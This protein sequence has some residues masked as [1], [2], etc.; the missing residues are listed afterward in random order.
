V[1]L[2]WKH[3][4]GGTVLLAIL[5]GVAVVWVVGTGL[6][7]RWML[8][9]IVSQIETNTGT[10]V[11]VGKFHFEFWRLRAEIDN[12][13]VH[14]L[15]G[16]GLPP[17]FH[18]DHI[19]IGVRIISFFR[20]EIALDELLA[21]R[22]QVVMRV[23][24][25]GKSNLPPPRASSGGAPWA[26]TLFNLRARH[27]ELRDGSATLNDRRLA[28]T[29]QGQDLNFTLQYAAPAAG[30]EA[31]LG[32]FSWQ[33]V[34]LAEQGDLPFRFDIS[35][36]F[37]LHRNAFDIDELVWKLPHSEL[38]LQAQ[39]PDLA[40]AD[41][42]FRYRGRLSLQDVRTIFRKPTTP[43]A[44]TDFSGQ[45]SYASE[46][47]AGSE[48]TTAGNYRSHDIKLPY[49]WFHDAG[50]ETSGDYTVARQHLVVPNL[51]V[52]A[53]GGSVDGRLEMD[54]HGLAFRTQTHLHGDSLRSIFAAL[55]NPDFPVHTLHWDASVDVD[56]VNTWNANFQH[57]RSTGTSVWS[58][59][60][61]LPVGTMPA[62]ATINYDYSNDRE[63]VV[64]QQSEI[65][66]PNTQV[67]FAGSL[68]AK[69]SALEVQL[70]AQN[71]TDWDDFIN[72]LR[73]ADA[74]PVAVSGQ[75][76]WTG[77]ILGPLGGPTFA[78]H[79]RA[80]QA[81]Y[82][83]LHWD[84]LDGELEYSPDDFRLTKTTVERG[85]TSV[86]MD[87]SLE[88]DGAWSFLPSSSWTLQAHVNRA[89]TEDVQ[90]VFETKYPIT[91]FLSGDI[92]GS[93][94]RAAPVL[95]ANLALE[96]IEATGFHFDRLS[97]QLHWEGD[98]IRLTGGELREGTGRLTGDFLYHPHEG[99][100]EFNLVGRA[101]SLE[102]IGA[103]QSASLPIS[104][105]L[106]FDL[107][108]SG[109]LRQ[110]VAQ[111]DL[112]LV[113][114]KLGAEVQGDFNGQVTSDGQ[115]AHVALT[116]ELARGKLDGQ[117]TMGF[118]G[119]RPI[120]GQISVQQFDIDPFITS[121]LYLKQLTGHS[122]VD[123]SFAISGA[124]RQPD[125]IEVDANITRAS[126][127]YDLVQLQNDGP[128]QLVYHR[129]EVRIG[130]LHLHGTDTDMQ[131]G[132]SA[133]FDRD[134][135]MN[136]T[137]TG[138]VNLRLLK[139]IVPDLAGQGKADVNVTV[140]GTI[141]QPQIVGRASVQDVS[142][143]Y[144]D[145]P[146]GLSKVNGEFIFD[147]SR[148]L[149]NHITA[150]AGGGQ[151]VL[152]GTVTYGEG[153]LRYSITAVTPTI[154]I[155]Y[156]AGMSWL[157]GGTLQLSGTTDA[158]VLSGN[159]QVQRLLFAE[160]VDVASFFAASSE[161]SAAS[162]TTSPFLRNLSFDIEGQTTPGT[163]IEW[164]GA[165][166]EMDGDVRLRGTWDRPVILGHVHLLG[167]QMAFRGNDFTLTRGDINFANPFRLDPV[168]NVEATSTI[169]EYQVTIDFSGPASHLSLNY[170][171]DPPLPD[172]DIIAL[173]ALGNT[174][175][176]GALRSQ[177]TA[178]QNYG[179]TALLSEA[180]STGLGGRIEHLFGISQ[181]R[182]DPFIAGTTTESNAAAR[183]TIEQRLAHGLTITYSTNAASNQQQLIQVEYAVRRDL[184]V[185]F[186]R[187]INGTNG[188]DIKWVKHLK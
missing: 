100:A 121:C 170:R 88:L 176:S 57:F 29:V 131:L 125:S 34:E 102:T 146:V 42:N 25:D 41:W 119:D 3:W 144:A 159:I 181:F 20:R 183:V 89:S 2:G 187:D 4:T 63:E 101:I 23:D 17:L 143:S 124:L 67:E 182:V 168:L 13:T 127:D 44:I 186:L 84:S 19:E 87:L 106:E 14:G 15:E 172:S 109:P 35:T 104:G 99:T 95:D 49:V 175:E 112:K 93:G 149:F 155:R 120:S 162:A 177:S 46:A 51:K 161:S 16:A 59:P 165:Q 167:G 85:Q 94:T 64:V 27:V 188:F 107:K 56:S 92:R 178:S 31:Y 58:A 116:S 129:N 7:D 24:K 73:G 148:L 157:A 45:A 154:R 122:S 12:V 47:P 10:R 126:F 138:S 60:Q 139:G 137:L 114:L 1:K 43:D 180:I 68:G 110:P 9:Q 140:Q 75:V 78:G 81:H 130:Q 117:F 82:A 11:E 80:N 184:S 52:R 38:D 55:E 150:E 21:D 98:E 97:G 54:F 151:M 135:P 86:L 70:R 28:L 8:H 185:E 142:A 77:R 147:T 65:S 33:R 169:S 90:E 132:G 6:A 69:D 108:G 164:T 66:T 166:V 72:I 174:G 53:L 30:A 152:N 160:G 5:A 37:T 153:P 32:N 36:K 179:A 158:A 163:L 105:Q 62:T 133:R 74:E 83:D 141:A 18:A 173:L 136:F 128:V 50:I 113:N 61:T 123:G 26:A 115:S 76:D 22:P 103:L 39:L 134:R 96:Q 79:V 111:G 48:W 145:F 40:R 71:L 171:S 118:G 156:P 91:G